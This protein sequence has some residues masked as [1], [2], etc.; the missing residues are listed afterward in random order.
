MLTILTLIT[1]LAVSAVAGYFSIV[2]L[3]A[4]FS[5]APIPIAIMG[6]TL[7]VAK[8]VTAS[9]IYRNWSTAPIVIKGYFIT[10]V[11][12]LSFITSLGIFGY[13]SKAHIEQ[14]T[15]SGD[16]DLKIQLIDQ[17]INR[18]Q[19]RIDDA[20]IVISQLDKSVQ[21]LIDANRIR[22]TSGSISVRESQK[23]ERELLNDTINDASD[24]ISSLNEEK[25]TLAQT[26][27]NLEAEV[28]PLK[29]ISEFIY[30]S[31]EKS[32]LD[33]AVRWVIIL[34]IFVFDPLAILLLIAFNMSF[35]KSKPVTPPRRKVTE[36]EDTTQDLIFPFKSNENSNEINIDKK[37]IY[38][39]SKNFEN[40][41]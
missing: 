32:T 15:L 11:L 35:V 14:T 31:A 39:I 5:S 29:Y 18:E 40:K 7:E 34:I 41:I 37:R 8:L 20:E 28:G 16:N 10:A 2:G 19:K 4:I 38:N 12:I 22:G 21:A 33:K 26:R 27:L 3:I 24:K 23:Q 9:W 6:G 36:T 1:A 30:G 13:L 17:R 25:L